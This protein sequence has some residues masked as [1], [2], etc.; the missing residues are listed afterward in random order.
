MPSGASLDRY[1]GPSIRKRVPRIA[2]RLKPRRRASAGDFLGNMYPRRG[3]TL[4]DKIEPLVNRVVGTDQQLRSGADQ[5][6]RRL[7]HHLT[8]R[9]PTILVNQTLVVAQREAVQAD[10]RM[11][12]RPEHRRAFETDRAITKRRAF[13]ADC[14]D[15]DM[16]QGLFPTA[17]CH[18]CGGCAGCCPSSGGA[19]PQIK[20]SGQRSAPFGQTTVP[21]S[22]RTLAKTAGSLRIGSNTGPTSSRDTSRSITE[23]S[24]SSRLNLKPSR[25][26]TSR[27]RK[28]AISLRCALSSYSAADTGMK[29]IVPFLSLIWR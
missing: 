13:S 14:N 25:T 26:L 16:L 21:P 23:P 20:T 22:T 15:A 11:V 17:A 19:P 24:V 29:P 28:S 6:R 7:E 1:T 5:V 8:H 3:R 27:I 10:L 12:M 4:A 18:A 9:V 2:I